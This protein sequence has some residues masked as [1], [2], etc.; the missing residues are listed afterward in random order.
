MKQLRVVD[1]MSTALLTGAPD[2]IVFGAD[3]DMRIAGI[4]HLPV[5]D[6]R[7]RLCGI[8]SDR[9]LLVALTKKKT[10]RL[11]DVMTEDVVTAPENMPAW[12]AAD[13]MLDQGIHA[14]PILGDEGQLVGVVTET[15]LL[16]YVVIQ[17]RHRDARPDAPV[18]LAG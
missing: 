13:L 5:V 6:D 4:R 17:G 18:D 2:D 7:G 9:D 11:R 3:V 14:L 8:I 10:V 16:R 12:E 1:L 15:D